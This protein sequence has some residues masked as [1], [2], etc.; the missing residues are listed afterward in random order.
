MSARSIGSG[1]ITF[2]L[3]N[4]PVK[5]FSTSE[6]GTHISFNQLHK[7][8][9]GRI[10]QQL[11]CPTDDVV[12]DRD[13]LVKGYEFSKDQYVVFTEQEL[14]A[15]EEES[16]K[17]MEISEFVPLSSV[18][19][20]YFES[21]YY[22]GPDKGAERAF[23]LLAVA[24]RDSGHAAVAKYATRGRQ[25]LVLMRPLGDCLVMQQLHYAD[26]VK[27]P[28]EIP[29]GDVDLKPPELALARQFIEQLSTERFDPTKYRDEYRARLQEV[30]DKKVKGETVTFAPAQAH[31]PKVVDL[32]E[33]LR[34]SLA[35]GPAKVA[36]PGPTTEERKPPRRAPPREAAPAKRVKSSKK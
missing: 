13:D 15:L 10:K 9:N 29:V 26:E 12:V 14:K 22:L 3:V 6:G 20:L 19:P 16:S 2:G 27:S 11:Y 30:I 32:M 4:I 8:C 31:S 35:R 21:G 34:A 33:A 25:N 5:L 7:T 23:K 17:A 1:T 24:L 18:D 36:P 28:A